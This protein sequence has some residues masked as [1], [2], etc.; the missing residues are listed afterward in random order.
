MNPK[1]QSRRKTSANKLEPIDWHEFANDAVLNGNMSTLYRRPPTEDPSAYAS[2]EAMVEIEKRWS[3][4]AEDAE[5][6]IVNSSAG[7][8]PPMDRTHSGRATRSSNRTRRGLYYP[9]RSSIAHCGY[10]ISAV[11]HA[12]T[13]SPPTAHPLPT[14][15]PVPTDRV[16]PRPPAAP[17]RRHM[18]RSVQ[19][20]Q[21]VPATHRGYYTHSGR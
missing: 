16:S 7:S 21:R 11:P 15:G 13:G 9:L 6:E 3:G 17:M 10:A 14:V 12:A 2:P 8:S 19:N 5:A 1:K 20:P 4:L 18:P